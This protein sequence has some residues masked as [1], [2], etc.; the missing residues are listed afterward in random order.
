MGER[1]VLGECSGAVVVLVR[2][3]SR[4]VV[5]RDGSSDNGACGGATQSRRGRNRRGNGFSESSRSYLPHELSRG[6]VGKVEH[7]PRRQWRWRE[8]IGG[9]FPSEQPKGERS[10]GGDSVF[11]LWA[12]LGV[13]MGCPE[14]SWLS[15]FIDRPWR[16]AI[17]EIFL[18]GLRYFSIRVC[19]FNAPVGSPQAEQ[20]VCSS[21]SE[22]GV[23]IF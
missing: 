14:H 2:A 13:V 23:G 20:L 5:D 3:L 16:L 4:A 1:G 21:G 15:L 17:I 22:G 10:G 18:P 8:R 7:V 19:A 11:Q 12:E 6:V 9:S